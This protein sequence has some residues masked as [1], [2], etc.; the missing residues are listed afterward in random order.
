MAKSKGEKYVIDR[1]NDKS[2]SYAKDFFSQKEVFFDAL[3][4]VKGIMEKMVS[5]DD[6]KS[7]DTLKEQI[8]ALD[9]KYQKVDEV[10]RDVIQVTEYE[11]D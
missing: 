4:E 11:V 1:L 7:I 9:K 10:L 8:A 5:E 6:S 3:V 2:S